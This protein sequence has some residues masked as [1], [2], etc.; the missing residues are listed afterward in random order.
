MRRRHK[1]KGELTAKRLLNLQGVFTSAHFGHRLF[2]NVDFLKGP[3]GKSRS[4][5]QTEPKAWTDRLL[6]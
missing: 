6:H 1:S 3:S 2:V 4:N 5:T